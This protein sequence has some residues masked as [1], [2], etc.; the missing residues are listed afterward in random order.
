MRKPEPREDWPE[1]WKTAYRFDL[2]EV[3]GEGRRHRG[4]A[5]AYAMRRARTLELVR[6]VAAPGARVLDV[7]A[8]QG[9]FTLALAEEGYAVT[10][11]DLREE[12]IGYVKL[13]HERGDV[14]YLPGEVFQLTP[15]S[16]FD[17]VVATEVIEHVAHPDQFL[18]KLAS[19]VRPGGY[20]VMTTPNGRYLRNRLPRFSEFEDPS[21]FEAGQ[22][23]PD[24]DGHIFLLHPDEVAP[25]ARRAGL[26]I[27]EQELFTNFLSAGW[28]GT[29]PLTQ[30]LP[31]AAVAL[32]E[33]VT[34]RLPARLK[35]RVTTNMAFLLRRA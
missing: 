8:A 27:A 18:Q 10:W 28:L 30:R 25:L 6:K 17:V 11:N 1:S 35:E 24:A 14:T 20:L 5:N 12:L 26:E 9:N 13:K 16:P 22:F 31:E 34:A 32:G 23:K 29:G 15:P 7:A 3:F 33:K 2:L 19:F 21:V 4:Y